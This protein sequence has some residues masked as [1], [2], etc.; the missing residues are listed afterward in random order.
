MEERGEDD[1]WCE[2]SWQVAGEPLRQADVG[3]GASLGPERLGEVGEGQR[4]PFPAK[5]RLS[6]AT[7]APAMA[8]RRSV[9]FANPA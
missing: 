6:P 4:K 9:R 8:G 5:I 2:N 7:T 1:K 3:D